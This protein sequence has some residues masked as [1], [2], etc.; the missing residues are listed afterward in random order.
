MKALYC[1]SF[2]K[3]KEWVDTGLKLVEYQLGDALITF[4]STDFVGLSARLDTSPNDFDMICQ[5]MR[6]TH[7]FLENALLPMAFEDAKRTWLSRRLGEMAH[8][9][10]VLRAIITPAFLS[11]ARSPTA[12][13]R[14]IMRQSEDH[15]LAAKFAGLSDK[16]RAGRVTYVDGKEYVP[17]LSPVRAIVP[18]KQ[19][20]TRLLIGTDDL[21]AIFLAEIEQMAEQNVSLAVCEYCGKLFRPYSTKTRYCDRLFADTSKTCKELAAKDKYQKKIAADEGL[22]LYRRRNNAYLMRVS[23]APEIYKD[24]DYQAWKAQ[25]EAALDRYVNGEISLEELCPSLDL[26]PKK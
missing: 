21:E 18:P 25:A 24:A 5:E 1:M 12:M 13:Q 23:R 26:P 8:L 11:S 20:N 14:L 16:L 3:N 15:T 17:L 2:E 9:Q 4:L 7:P 6:G 19:V 22:S 10:E